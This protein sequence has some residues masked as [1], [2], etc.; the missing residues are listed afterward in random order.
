M[1]DNFSTQAKGYAQ[2][3]PDYPQDLYNSIFARLSSYSCAWDCATGN[4]QVALQL[5]EKFD[6]V[7]ATD[8]SQTQLDN[9]VKH[10]NIK[11]HIA[12]AENSL[13]P[14]QSVD[15]ITVAQAIH[16]FNHN[17]FLKEAR[18]VAA[19]QA[20]LCYFG[21][22]LIDINEEANKIIRH[23]HDVVIGP[24]WDPERA[25]LMNEYDDISFGLNHYE[26]QYFKY[27]LPWTIEHMEGYL[28]T[29]SSVQ[30]YIKEHNEN[31]VPAVIKHLKEVWKENTITFPIFLHCG[32]L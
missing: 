11:Y 5:A 15:L 22:G 6:K 2:Y 31:P 7:I 17:A 23:I 12:S 1:K 30:K 10:E 13:L 8:I 16:W 28:N 18:R 4:G 3:R 9:A 26:K 19:P 24:Y 14:D 20:W 21:Y 29:W 25:I 27:T 32:Q